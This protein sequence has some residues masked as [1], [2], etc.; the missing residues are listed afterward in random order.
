ML[1]WRK[2]ERPP[3]NLWHVVFSILSLLDTKTSVKQLEMNKG[4]TERN[5]KKESIEVRV[6]RTMGNFPFTEKV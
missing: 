6:R 1:P 4:M 3:N 5:G 2:R